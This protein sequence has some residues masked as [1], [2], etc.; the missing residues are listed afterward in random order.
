MLRK[1]ALGVVAAASIAAAGLL[2][3]AASAS[4]LYFGWGWGPSYHYIATPGYVWNTPMAYTDSCLQQRYVQTR[5]GMR[6]RTVNV[7]Y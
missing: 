2:P 7:C 5:R 1:I 4:P 6:L 3:T